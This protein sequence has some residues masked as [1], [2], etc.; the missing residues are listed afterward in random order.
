MSVEAKAASDHA[1]LLK[2]GSRLDSDTIPDDLVKHLRRWCALLCTR[3]LHLQL[4]E[5]YRQS[6]G[7]YA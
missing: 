2:V 4:R 6:R 5:A 3:L 7:D 1:A